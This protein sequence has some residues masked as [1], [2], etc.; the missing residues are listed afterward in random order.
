MSTES[1]VLLDRLD[2]GVAVVTLNSPKVNALSTQLLARLLDVATELT[3]Q[4]A[5]AV[6][7]TGGDRLFAAGADISQF[8]GPEEARTIG[9]AFHSALNAVAVIPSFTIAAVSG[10]ALGGGCELALA[11]DYRMVSTKA[12]FG[13]P[14]IL[15]GIMP[16]GGGTQ[17]LLRLIG[18][19]RAKELMMTGR[20]VKATEALQIGLADEV[21]E[22][23][24]LMTRVLELAGVVASGATHAAALIKQAVNEGLETDI[25]TGLSHELAL[26]EEVFHT[27]DS[28]IG[29]AS[30]LEHG[31]GKATFTGK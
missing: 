8:G 31:P 2:N 21:T 7:I 23:E 9:A 25:A 18:A 16:G 11:C 22:P 29:V 1:L 27:K 12:V 17:R 3:Q 6:V 28:N 14:E 4:P 15:L 30:F 20:Q 10:F 13:Q 5:G 24:V 26:F 19:S